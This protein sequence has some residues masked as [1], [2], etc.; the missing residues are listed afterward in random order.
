LSLHSV[1]IDAPS[2]AFRRRREAQEEVRIEVLDQVPVGGC[3]RMVELVHNDVVERVGPEQVQVAPQ[4]LHAGEDELCVRV[5]GVAD[6]QPHRCV[7][8]DVTK[9]VARLLQDLLPV[10]DEQ[11][12]LCANFL[13]IKR[14]E[15]GLAQPRRHD[16]QARLLPLIARDGQVGERFLLDLVWDGCL[17]LVVLDVDDLVQ[18]GF[19]DRWDL[20]RYGTRHGLNLVQHVPIEIDAS[21]VRPQL[22]ERLACELDCLDADVPLDAAGQPRAG[23][24]AG[25][26]VRARGCRIGA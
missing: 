7:G 25:A 17:D 2:R 21:G 24:V 23:Q 9:R 4:R 15:V 3:G 5:P 26:D 22:V 20:D 8:D 10:S 1:R 19:S 12:A 11:D 16:H 18:Y 6:K 13:D 14:R